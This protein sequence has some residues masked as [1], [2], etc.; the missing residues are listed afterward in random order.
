MLKRYTRAADYDSC[1]TSELMVPMRDGVNLATDIYVPALNSKPV[2]GKFPSILGRTP[3]NKAVPLR[4]VLPDPEFFVKRGYVVF[5]QD[6]RGR[7]QSE[8][9]FYP[10]INEGPDGYDTVEWIAHQPWSNGL[11]GTTGHSYSASVQDA[12]ALERPP[13][14]KAMFIGGGSTNYHMDTEGTGGAFRLVHNL[15][16][17]LHLARDMEKDA[18]KAKVISTWLAE[19]EKNA[20]DW[21]KRPLSKQISIFG[22]VAEAKKW[23]SDWIEHANFDDYWRQKGYCPEEYFDQYPDIP[24]YRSVG[25]YEQ[26]SRSSI[27]SHVELV[28]RN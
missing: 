8:G 10:Y 13:Q 22:G 16:Y 5:Q 6:V 28:N 27:V 3:Y 25:H 19:C 12:V 7:F 11:V 26:Y 18:R 14:L 24:I 21:L 23:Y 20:G 2:D 9:E 1:V 4:S 17:S 15:M